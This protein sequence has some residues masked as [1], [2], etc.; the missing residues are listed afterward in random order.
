M[1]LKW[2]SELSGKALM[3][4]G[5]LLPKLTACEAQLLLKS[6]IGCWRRG[7]NTCQK[8]PLSPKAGLLRDWEDSTRSRSEVILRA[9]TLET[10]KVTKLFWGC[11]IPTRK[12]TTLVVLV[13]R[14]KLKIVIN[15]FS[16]RLT[17]RVTGTVRKKKI[18]KKF[19]LIF[20]FLL[21]VQSS[22]VNASPDANNQ[23]QQQQTPNI[24]VF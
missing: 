11:S 24:H 13:R 9:T 6:A 15:D 1:H 14:R 21:Q 12:T 3:T 7:E 16:G 10:E 2:H 17:S 22:C 23:Q 18:I 5:E 8:T 20:F 4:S 19:N